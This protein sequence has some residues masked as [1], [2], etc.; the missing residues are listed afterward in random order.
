MSENTTGEHMARNGLFKRT[1]RLLSTTL[2]KTE[3]ITYETL[4]AVDMGFQGLSNAVEEFRNES[5]EDLLDSRL[6]TTKKLV[7]VRAIAK[8]LGLSDDEIQAMVTITRTE[9]RI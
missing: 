3:S 1:G 9:G 5:I 6:N 7:E 4:N 2:D 8:E